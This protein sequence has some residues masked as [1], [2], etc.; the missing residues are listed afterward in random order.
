LKSHSNTVP[1]NQHADKILFQKKMILRCLGIVILTTIGSSVFAENENAE[2]PV[3]VGVMSIVTGDLALVGKNI[4]RTAGTYKKHY[5]RHNLEFFFEDAK[6][7]SADGAKAS[8]SLISLKKVD[9]LI[10]GCS[11]NGLVASKSLINSSKTPTISIVTGGKNADEAGRYVFRIG[12]SD[13]LNGYL[14][15]EKFFGDGIK[16]VAMITE[17]TDYTNDVNS[18]FEK[19][20]VELGGKVSYQQTFLPGTN[21]FR[22]IAA[23]LKKS[24]PKAL[25]MATQDGTAFGIFLKQW[26]EQSGPAIPIHTTFVAA[27]NPQ[28]HE[29]AG[30]AIVGV[31]FMSP[32]YDPSSEKWKKFVALYKSD[33]ATEP[34]IAFHSAGV[35]D[36][37]DL[38]QLYLDKHETFD[39]EG[40]ADYLSSSVKNYDGYMGRFSFDSE[41]NAD[42]S[43][44]FRTIEKSQKGSLN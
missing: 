15:A 42:T 29:I 4:F 30:E 23:T 8:M 31:G 36:A 38:L 20:F 17:E 34:A 39:R 22:S 40:F 32:K 44:E 2:L 27:P 33:Y 16:E 11:T 43:F 5:L 13:T 24:S 28:A 7:G 37:L 18:A 6:L 19:R 21:D 9:I 10:A 35:L 12:N 1:R 25:M 3:K 14:E 41:G 26:R